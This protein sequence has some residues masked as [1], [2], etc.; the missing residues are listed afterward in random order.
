MIV[1]VP[2]VLSDD[3]EVPFPLF[4]GHEDQADVAAARAP[5]GDLRLRV[6]DRIATRNMPAVVAIHGGMRCVGLSIITDQC[7]PD[8]LEPAELGRIIATARKAEPAL[9]KLVTTL[10]ERLA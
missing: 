8:A 5:V 1:I 7:L 9:S 3:S 10:V 2:V 4:V 6:Y